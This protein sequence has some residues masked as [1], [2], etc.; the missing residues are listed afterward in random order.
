MSTIEA[1][2]TAAI[3]SR[4]GRGISRQVD[5]THTAKLVKAAAENP[6]AHTIT[7]FAGWFV[8][9]SYKYA[10]PMEALILRRDEETGSVSVTLERQD[11]TRP[12]GDGPKVT[13]QGKRGV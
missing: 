10:A 2:A 6:H 3:A 4:K 1:L 12:G 7:V 13:I 11:A 8:P 9:N 5:E